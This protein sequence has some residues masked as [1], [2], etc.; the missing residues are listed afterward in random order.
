[1]AYLRV[2]CLQYLQVPSVAGGGGVGVWL[3]GSKGGEKWIKQHFCGGR[4]QGRKECSATLG[5]ILQKKV[6]SQE[7]QGR[8]DEISDM[9]HGKIGLLYPLPS[10]PPTSYSIIVKALYKYG[11]HLSKDLLAP[12]CWGQFE[13]IAL[14][15]LEL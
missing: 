1:M 10:P 4:K 14:L 2:R 12:I 3:L 5:N 6:Q 11:H 15:T 13:R 9:G 7:C 8:D